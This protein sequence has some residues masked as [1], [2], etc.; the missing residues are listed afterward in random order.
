MAHSS[1]GGQS[2]G[3]AVA[4]SSS[5]VTSNLM[6]DVLS[7]LGYEVVAV[8]RGGQVLNALR[9]EAPDLVVFDGELPEMDV[10]SFLRLARPLLGAR[11]VPVILA[12]EDGRQLSRADGGDLVEVVLNAGFS[13]QELK[14]AVTI[15]MWAADRSHDPK[16]SGGA[17]PS[18]A[19]KARPVSRA[20]RATPSSSHSVPEPP[21]ARS[22]K[23]TLLANGTNRRDRTPKS[24]LPATHAAARI[25]QGVQPKRPAPPISGASEPERKTVPVS[26]MTRSSAPPGPRPDPDSSSVQ[27]PSAKKRFRKT[28]AFTPARQPTVSTESGAERAP[29]ESD[30]QIDLPVFDGDQFAD[31]ARRADEVKRAAK[32][33]ASAE[34]PTRV[35]R[36]RKK[37]RAKGEPLPNGTLIADRYVV[38]NLLGS[39]GM[40]EVYR[41]HDR[42]LEEEVALKLLKEDKGDP[43]IQARFRQEMRICRRLSH[44]AIVRTYEFGVWSGRRFLTMEVLEGDDMARVLEREGKPLDEQRAIRLFA[45]VCMGLDAAHAAGVIHRDVKPHNIF[46]LKG[47]KKARIM[48]FGI[49]KTED[50]TTTAEVGMSVI[51]T[52]AYLPPER[53]EHGTAL[54]PKTD[55]YAVGASLYHAL[56]GELPFR[57]RDLKSLL[58]AIV[59]QPPT[60]PRVHR[61]ELSLGIELLILQAMAK[62]PDLRPASCADFADRLQQLAA[63]T[64]R[65]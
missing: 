20:T 65:A 37:R 40:A 25:S 2:A 5:E 15:A 33:Q 46:V 7:G 48:D 29:A 61:P 19:F 49:A 39:G 43:E 12:R 16:V 63:P 42:E 4:V 28:L 23:A 54:T 21:R 22:K 56:T 52:P 57:A 17:R 44:P 60:P 45:Q 30:T 58:T 9:L 3:T 55:V 10:V 47:D 41:V 26:D 51:G 18:D 36:K 13:P 50:L 8:Q 11:K 6:R 24:T 53:L 1:A 27:A 59:I 34:T 14:D 32:A 62:D 35:V 64:G 31:K 38:R